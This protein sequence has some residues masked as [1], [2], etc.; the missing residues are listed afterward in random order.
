M[1]KLFLGVLAG[2]CSFTMAGSRAVAA[3]TPATIVWNGTQWNV[4]SGTGKNPGLN[5]WSPA[6]VFVDAN[7]DLHLS[8]TNVNGTWYCSEVW[9]DA[10]LGF[11]TFQWQ[12]TSA[13]DNLDPNV[14][15]GLFVYGPTALGPDGTHEIDIEYSRFSSPTADVGRWTVFPNVIVTPPLLGRSA[16]PLALGSNPA[17]TSRFTWGTTNVA[18]AT[19]DGL[20]PADSNAGLIQSWTYQPSDAGT[21]ISQSPMPVH[22]NLWLFNGAAPSN[23][24]GVEVVVHDFSYT[25]A[26]TSAVPALGDSPFVPAACLAACLTCVGLALVD[27]RARRSGR[28]G[29]SM[30]EGPR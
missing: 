29:P 7:G 24:Q 26:V 25:P 13:V 14:V 23:G 10:P 16:Y 3:S 20:Q 15:L 17:T 30:S 1:A 21:T 28:A 2:A 5:S 8:I 4:K 9:A 22:M 6:N 27:R 12:L 11:G 18:F 19:F